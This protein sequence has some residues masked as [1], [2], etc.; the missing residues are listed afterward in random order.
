MK[1]TRLIVLVLLIVAAAVLLWRLSPGCRQRATD[2]YR[3]YG[4]WT[5]EARKA[6]PVGFIEHAQQ[7]LEQDLQEFEEARH[8]LA[9]A[10]ERVIAEIEQNRALLQEAD[11]LAVKYR[12]AYREAETEGYPV[13]VSGQSY[14]REQLL[15]Q[16][17]LI[18]LQR[19]SFAETIEGLERA[20]DAI[21]EKQPQLVTQISNIEAA[22][23]TLPSKKEIANV[24]QLTGRA[25]ELLGQ[26]DVLMDENADLLD[27]SPVRTVEE[28]IEH[29]AQDEPD[30]GTVDVQAFLEA[31]E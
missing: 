14:N 15:E 3:K 21:K 11:G 27:E 8:S 25:A 7:Q 20:A 1:G 12:D 28:L 18:L 10:R 29:R 22:L 2:A 4:G 16:V 30:T 24:N 19:K 9:A 5:E 13:T 23:A 31:D 6:D 17:Q 26:V